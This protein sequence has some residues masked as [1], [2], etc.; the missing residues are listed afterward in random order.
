MYDW[1][2]HTWNPIRGECPHRCT[3]C[4]MKGKPVGE[5]RLDDEALNDN[6]GSG[7]TIFVGSSVDMWHFDVPYAWIDKVLDRCWL[8]AENL[9]LFQT[10]N[11]ARYQY[12]PIPENATLGV[13]LE[14]N[15]ATDEF[16]RAPAPVERAAMM[17][18]ITFRKK[19]VSIEPVMD[20]DIAE[21]LRWITEWI[22]PVFVSI[23]ADTRGCKLPEPP[24]GKLRELI[25]E[26]RKITE[27]RLKANLRRILNGPTRTGKEKSRC[28]SLNPL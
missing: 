24:P 3:Y 2:T 12:M 11:P 7:R 23:G 9:F 18:G 5:L 4:Y 19:M 10:K 17:G 15:R 20:F 8:S 28:C 25:D 21:I 13:T 14:T 1:V 27:V 6:L 26:L 16:S 22:Q